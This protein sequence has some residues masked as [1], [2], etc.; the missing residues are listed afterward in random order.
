MASV[1]IRVLSDSGFILVEVS[2]FCAFNQEPLENT[3]VHW[4]FQP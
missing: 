2:N 3:S 4:T 1:E